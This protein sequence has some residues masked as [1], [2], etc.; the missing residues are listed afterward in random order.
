MMWDPAAA[1]ELLDAP[2]AKA[3]ELDECSPQHVQDDERR[4]LKRC[5]TPVDFMGL[6]NRTCRWPLFEG[7]EPFYEKLYCG[8]RTSSGS[9]YCAAH[10]GQAGIANKSTRR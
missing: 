3:A 5:D 8:A 4:E 9:H 2:S 7:Y 6:N 10:A 1:Q